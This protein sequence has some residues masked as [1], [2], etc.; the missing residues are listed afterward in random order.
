MEP[1][2]T[3]MKTSLISVK[4]LD[5]ILHARKTAQEHR[6]NQLLV[7]QKGKL[8]GILTDREKDLADRLLEPLD[9]DTRL[10]VGHEYRCSMAPVYSA[11][12][13]RLR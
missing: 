12:N 6:V 7:V 9:I 3:V 13:G 8:L 11:M 10:A 4:P 2:A 5:T 1:L